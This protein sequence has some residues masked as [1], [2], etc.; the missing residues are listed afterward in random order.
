[1]SR[2]ELHTEGPLGNQCERAAVLAVLVVTGTAPLEETSEWVAHACANHAWE[3]TAV[4]S[5]RVVRL[6]ADRLDGARV[7]VLVEEA[8]EELL[9]LLTAGHTIGDRWPLAKPWVA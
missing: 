6:R 3:A 7:V 2:C 4:A 9:Y 5:H 8:G 1:M